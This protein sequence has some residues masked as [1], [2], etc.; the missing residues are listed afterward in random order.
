MDS[1]GKNEKIVSQIQNCTGDRQEL[2]TELWISNLGL[3]QKIIHQATGLQ[4]DI[5][6][7]DFEDLEQQAFIGIMD[8]VQKYEPAAGV[9]FFTYAKSYIRKSI[10]NYYDRN[11]QA[12]R[13]PA[14]MRKRIKEYMQVRENLHMKGKSATIENIQEILSWSDNAMRSVVETIR[15]MEMQRFDS[16]LNES[17]KD[18]GT[19]LDMLAN[20][21][22]VCEDALAGSY[23]EEL[24]TTLQKA[25]TALPDREQFVLKALFFQGYSEKKLA[26]HMGCTKQNMSR[27]KRE[28]FRQIRKGK[29]GKE[30]IEFLPERAINKAEKRIQDD[31]K[32]L[33]EHERKLLI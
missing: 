16:Y 27:I 30:L 12:L 5:H 13:L 15:K 20:S 14:Y 21:E 6:R 25:M 3:V 29:Y 26:E 18:S 9:K 1:L 23:A 19:V 11:G 22:N 28:A 10:Y 32:D 7:Q 2:L 4:R 24:R 31:F 8:A 33:N 17:D